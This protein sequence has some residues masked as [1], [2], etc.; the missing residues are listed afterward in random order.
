MLTKAAEIIAPDDAPDPTPLP[1]VTVGDVVL[2][3]DSEVEA[4]HLGPVTESSARDF[5]VGGMDFLRAPGAHPTFEAFLVAHAATPEP[6]PAHEPELGGV[7][8]H[9]RARCDTCSPRILRAAEVRAIRSALGLSLNAFAAAL[10]VNAR[11]PRTWES[12]RTALSP[13]SSAA[14]RDL[15]RAFY[16]ASTD[17]PLS[18]RTSRAGDVLQQA[19]PD[20]SRVVWG[21]RL[22]AGIAKGEM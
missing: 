11:T 12:G 19:S 9:D 1:E 16:T 7:A 2:V 18:A 14:I 10:G 4:W 8:D 5:T 13:G 20:L 6:T 22:I 3:W 21:T 17:D 15:A